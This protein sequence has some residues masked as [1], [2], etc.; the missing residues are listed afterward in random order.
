MIDLR[1]VFIKFIAED[2][3]LSLNTQISY[4]SDLDQFISFLNNRGVSNLNQIT[5]NTIVQYMLYL[6]KN[7]KAASTISRNL[8]SIRSFYCFLTELGYVKNNPTQGLEAPRLEKKAPQILSE[9][10]VEL[11]L[12]Q[13]NVK[14]VRGM[15]DK[16]MLEL[17]YSTGIKVSE[18][19]NLNIEDVS[20]DFSYIKIRYGTNEKKVQVKDI[21]E[22]LERYIKLSRPVLLGNSNVKSLFLNVN[23][24]RLTRQGFWKIVKNYRINCRM[25]K[26]ITPITLRHSFAAH[27]IS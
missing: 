12:S 2:K 13:P 18:L 10:E 27:L 8:A 25:K 11:L 4:K 14:E 5:K 21:K 20:E 1:D 24:G 7:G 22:H 16:A 6:R 19:T 17:L 9:E 3:R 26:D 15:R 23:G